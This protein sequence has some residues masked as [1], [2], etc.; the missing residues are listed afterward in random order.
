MGSP[1]RPASQ[2]SFRVA[3]PGGG[4][5]PRSIRCAA[6]SQG[7]SNLVLPISDRGRVVSAANGVFASDLT[8]STH[9]GELAAPGVL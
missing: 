3:I 9:D 1:P 6:A 4:E 2:W 7:V 5:P 8:I